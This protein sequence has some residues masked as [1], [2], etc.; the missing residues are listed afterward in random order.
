MRKIQNKKAYF[1]L[2]FTLFTVPLHQNIG[3][4]EIKDATIKA[5][6]HVLTTPLS[7]I[8][9]DGQLTCVT[10][11]EGC[12]KSLLLRAVMG[13]H[14]LD[15][16]FVNIDGALLSP[17]SAHAFRQ[18]M[19]YLPQQMQLLA[20]AL[21]PPEAPVCEADDYAVWNALLPRVQK[22]QPSVPL[23]ADDILLLAERTLQGAP[24]KKIVI[25][26]DP[27]ALFPRDLSERM[28]Q[29][30]CLQADAGKTVLMAS[31]VPLFLEHADQVIEMTSES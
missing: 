26:D 6:E 16:G 22:A 23:S 18:Q 21:T 1:I 20:H 28:L 31:R 7:L 2:Y 9:K 5:G 25:A 27:A 19:V 30:L 13:F 17:R 10:G 8:A 14:P 3:M 24:D 29:L 12:G 15:S 11:P 4:L